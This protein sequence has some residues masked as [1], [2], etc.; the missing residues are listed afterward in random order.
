MLTL[1]IQGIHTIHRL[2]LSLS[3]ACLV[4]CRNSSHRFLYEDSML[5]KKDS[6]ITSP[7]ELI[8]PRTNTSLILRATTLGR[9]KLL[10][11]QYNS[12]I[13]MGY[14]SQ[15]L[16]LKLVFLRPMRT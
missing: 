13:T 12:K 9:T 4:L 3:N 14:A 1:D 11:L 8:L 5:C 6:L 15:N 7:R 2:Q 10:I 16:F